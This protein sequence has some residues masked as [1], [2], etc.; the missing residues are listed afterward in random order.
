MNK[1]IKLTFSKL[2]AAFNKLVESFNILSKYI[3]M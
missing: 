3:K 1:K 2:Q